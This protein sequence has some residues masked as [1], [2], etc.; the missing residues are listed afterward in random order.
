VLVETHTAEALSPGAAVLPHPPRPG[1]V[2]RTTREI[3]ERGRRH[4][5]VA[6]IR[7]METIRGIARRLAA[8]FETLDVL[9]TPALAQPPVPLGTLDAEDPDL[10]H[11]YDMTQRFAPFSAMFNMSGQPGASIPLHWTAEG[12][13]V[14]VQAAARIGDEAA[15][16]RLASQF[17][18]AR[19]WAA[20]RPPGLERV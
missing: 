6:Y 1:E 2:Q 19:P 10:D 15:L 7:A 13:P 3:A 5:A 8:V 4:D 11:F 17:E 9:L 18:T 12:L 16:I 14:G 20:R